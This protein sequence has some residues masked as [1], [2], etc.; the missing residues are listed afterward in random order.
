MAEEMLR[1]FGVFFIGGIGMYLGM[2][3]TA[4]FAEWLKARL[5]RDGER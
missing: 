2:Y 1:L 3:V 5:E 4:S